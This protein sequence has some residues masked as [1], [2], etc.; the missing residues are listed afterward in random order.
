MKPA[1]TGPDF[2]A[3]KERKEHKDDQFRQDFF[4]ISAFFCG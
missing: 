3:A 2:L 4:A 1:A